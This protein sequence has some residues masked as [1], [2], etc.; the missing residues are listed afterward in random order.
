M[1]QNTF[2]LLLIELCKTYGIHILNGGSPG[3]TECEITC[4][5]ND[6]YSTVDYFIA[7]S[8]LFQSV[9]KFEVLDRSESVHFPLSCCLTFHISEQTDTN[10][11]DEEA[12]RTF[13]KVKWRKNVNTRFTNNFNILFETM[14][15]SILN[16]LDVSINDCV[17]S[18]VEMY[19]KAA[20]CMKIK[21]GMPNYAKQE[22]WCDREC[23]QL[24]KTN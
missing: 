19:H 8:N 3:D 21:G 18:I 22:P 6:G 2:G 14:K 1:H 11:A 20:E 9:S 24:K 12:S 16:K 10:R 15:E 4:T 5:A 23:E 17:Q 7:S 13:K